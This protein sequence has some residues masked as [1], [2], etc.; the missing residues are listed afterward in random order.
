MLR[1]RSRE[2][3][4]RSDYAT[5]QLKGDRGQERFAALKA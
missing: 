5:D 4:G 3:I 2:R 1:A